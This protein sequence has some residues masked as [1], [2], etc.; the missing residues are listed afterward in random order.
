MSDLMYFDCHAVIGQR[1]RKHRRERWT[2]EHLLED[3]DVA[4]VAGALMVHAVATTYDP[5]YGNQRLGSEL[6]KAPDRLFGA[7]CV[8]PLDSPGFYETG[9]DM[10]RAMEEHD[11]RAARHVS[12]GLTP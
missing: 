3:M 4:E 6:V 2:T 7:W 8:A 10:L 9:D 11:V 12:G 1:P 5:I